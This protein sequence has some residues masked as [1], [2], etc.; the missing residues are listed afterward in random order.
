MKKCKECNVEKDKSLFYG[1]QGECKECT[2]ARVKANSK[3]VGSAY[4]FTEKGVIRVIYK[5][6][7]RH[8][9]LRGHGAM[10]Y[11]K[12]ELSDWLYENGFKVL[13]DAWSASGN[14]S[15]LKPSVDRIDDFKGYSFDNIT[16]STWDSNRKH[17]H[18]DIMNGVGTGGKRCK[19]L[20]RYN[21]KKELVATYVSYSQAVRDVGYSLEYQIRN[22]KM[23]RNGY[24]WSYIVSFR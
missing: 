23:C 14:L 13:F 11:T 5:T 3:K 2:K 6:Q 10:G 21:K 17:Q 24:Y 19:K 8:N 18:D 12:K 7:K 22:N 16:L 9:K 15:P 1:V 4:D 20:Y